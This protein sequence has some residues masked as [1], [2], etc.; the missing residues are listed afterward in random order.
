MLQTRYLGVEGDQAGEAYAAETLLGSLRGGSLPCSRSAPNCTAGLRWCMMLGTGVNG[1]L[2]GSNRERTKELM[3]RSSTSFK[4]NNTM[5]K[6]PRRRIAY[7]ALFAKALETDG[8]SFVQ[9]IIQYRD[10]KDPGLSL[11]ACDIFF[12]YARPPEREDVKVPPDTSY[13]RDLGLTLEE[14]LTLK[15]EIQETQ[16]ALVEEIVQR[17]IR[18]RE[19][20]AP[21]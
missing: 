8:D 19:P 14:G 16:S 6:G 7:D 21:I 2:T 5:S 17:L 20:Q 9:K 4:K 3:A 15:R 11:K 18:G 10:G 13:F 1:L 12:K